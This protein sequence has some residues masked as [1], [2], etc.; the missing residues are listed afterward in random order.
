M[1]SGVTQKP[2]KNLTSRQTTPHNDELLIILELSAERG[3]KRA[4]AD[5][6][7]VDENA[8]ADLRDLRDLLDA[9][10]MA[11]RTAW[12]T[13]VRLITTGLI[14]ALIA[15]VAIKLKVFGGQ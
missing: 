5:I 15:G 12:Q 8:A 13:V 10:R 3:A 14:L 6:G 11:K 1:R 2:L 4:L 7:L 9:I